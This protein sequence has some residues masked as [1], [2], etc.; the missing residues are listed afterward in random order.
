MHSES[1]HAIAAKPPVPNR[2]GTARRRT[3]CPALPCRRT[4]FRDPREGT[5][6]SVSVEGIV[7][8]LNK[9]RYVRKGDKSIHV[10]DGTLADD[11]G[12]IGVTF[13]DEDAK[14]ICEGMRIRIENGW[15]G[16]HYNTSQPNLS[17][18]KGGTLVVLDTPKLP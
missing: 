15:V 17:R 12:S 16:E 5:K 13:W 8:T 4:R 18:G 14:A 9:K 6:C 3:R 1:V 10:R 7:Q 2:P 11:S